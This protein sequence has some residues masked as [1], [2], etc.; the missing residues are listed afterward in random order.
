MA[1]LE[2]EKKDFKR[3]PLEWLRVQPEDNNP[4]I[5][6]ASIFGPSDSPYSGGQFPLSIH[7]PPEYPMQPPRIKFKTKIYHCDVNS[8]GNIRLDILKDGWSPACSVRDA[9][10]AI[11]NLLKKPDPVHNLN[12][13]IANLYNSN[14]TKHDLNAREWTRKY[15]YVT[16]RI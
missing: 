3:N 11:Y 1:R 7:F 9:L 16:N 13:A 14:K 4:L 8:V 10:S 5:W 6:Q 15:A 2:K 12:V